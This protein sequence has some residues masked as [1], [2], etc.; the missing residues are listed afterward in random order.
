M[1]V[2]YSVL[3]SGEDVDKRVNKVDN[4]ICFGNINYFVL[5][6]LKKASLIKEG[7]DYN[8]FKGIKLYLNEG[9]NY[10][11][12]HSIDEKNIMDQAF[13]DLGFDKWLEGHLIKEYHDNGT[14]KS[15]SFD[16]HVPI[17]LLIPACSI[18]RVKQ[19]HCSFL[20]IYKQLR[21]HKIKPRLAYF[22][23]VGCS[24]GT[25]AYRPTSDH[26]WKNEIP[27]NSLITTGEYTTHMIWPSRHF[28]ITILKWLSK[29]TQKEIFEN[30]L[31][32]YDSLKG[33]GYLDYV[34][35]DAWWEKETTLNSRFHD[36]LG[37]RIIRRDSQYQ[38]DKVKWGD[39]ITK[40]LRF[41]E[42]NLC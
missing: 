40:C 12:I 29:L 31:S 7:V 22:V 18:Y 30:S 13:I 16:E 23:T 19:N 37:C 3:H 9:S 14:V 20:D 36:I 24:S 41:Q 38:N 21:E 35:R 5:N 4:E 10:D 11:Q 33:K 2:S 42:K 28:S 25:L 17:F 39:L 8:I 27:A 15:L 1:S 34:G 32:M 6:I 26:P